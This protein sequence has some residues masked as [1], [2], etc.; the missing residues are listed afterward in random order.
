MK[1]FIELPQHWDEID[2]SRRIIAESW[3]SVQVSDIASQSA[4]RVNAVFTILDEGEYAGWTIY[5]TF[6]LD[7]EVGE[8]VFKKFIEVVGVKT[9]DR[10]LDVSACKHKILRVKVRHKTDD[11]GQTWA[12]IVAHAQNRE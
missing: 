5:E 11:A 3:Y 4:K 9:P 8:K 10:K 6:A 7:N 2:T 1:D 12:N